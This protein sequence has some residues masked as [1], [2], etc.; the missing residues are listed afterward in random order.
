MRSQTSQSNKK[1]VKGF[2]HLI[3]VLVRVV[4]RVT[5]GGIGSIVLAAVVIPC[6]IQYA[7]GHIGPKQS[8]PA[9]ELGKS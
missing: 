6:E 2:G 8:E 7:E 3:Y 1:A 9:K 4:V 5:I